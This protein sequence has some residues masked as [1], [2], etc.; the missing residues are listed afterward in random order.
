MYSIFCCFVKIITLVFS[1][2]H[3][4]VQLRVVSWQFNS[5]MAVI[6]KNEINYVFLKCIVY[7]NNIVEFR[8]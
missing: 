2:R 6:T 1:F 3:A 5:Y 7:S 4:W 8:Y